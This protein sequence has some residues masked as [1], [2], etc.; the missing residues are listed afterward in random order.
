MYVQ[1]QLTPVVLLD[2]YASLAHTHKQHAL[3]S[4]R[5]V[6]SDF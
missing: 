6:V 5:E 3:N 1:H 2:I 4:R